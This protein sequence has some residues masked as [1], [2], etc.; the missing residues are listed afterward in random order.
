MEQGGGGWMAID[1]TGRY[2]TPGSRQTVSKDSRR[3]GTK[4]TWFLGDTTAWLRE[5]TDA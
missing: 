4:G 1:W 2:G 3:Y 5:R